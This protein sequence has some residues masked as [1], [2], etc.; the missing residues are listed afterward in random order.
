MYR[1]GEGLDSGPQLQGTRKEFGLKLAL[2]GSIDAPPAG[3][4]EAPQ[5]FVTL[6]NARGSAPRVTMG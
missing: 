6:H 4:I 2:V 5:T 3:R 1:R